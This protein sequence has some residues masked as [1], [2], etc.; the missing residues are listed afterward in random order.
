MSKE[1]IVELD[2]E[3]VQ[4]LW[5]TSNLNF[6]R[7]YDDDTEASVENDEW[8]EIQRHHDKGGRFGIE[9]TEIFKVEI[10]IR[11][12]TK[13]VCYESKDCAFPDA[14]EIKEKCRERNMWGELEVRSTA[15]TVRDDYA[16]SQEYGVYVSEDFEK[17]YVEEM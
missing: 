13:S 9:E 8:E 2:W 5:K 6:F 1:W 4:F 12:D 3:Q 14:D 10:E 15:L 17:I 11:N 16:D 7:L